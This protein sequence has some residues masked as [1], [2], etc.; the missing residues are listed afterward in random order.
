[1]NNRR[2]KEEKRKIQV[3]AKRKKIKDNRQSQN[4]HTYI[5]SSLKLTDIYIPRQRKNKQLEIQLVI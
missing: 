5:G 2:D 1:M 4:S 3:R